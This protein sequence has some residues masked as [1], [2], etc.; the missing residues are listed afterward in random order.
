MSNLVY[1]NVDSRPIGVGV[2]LMGSGLWIFSGGPWSATF[3]PAVNVLACAADPLLPGV[4]VATIPGPALVPGAFVVQFY[5]LGSVWVAD[6][7][8]NTPENYLRAGSRRGSFSWD[9]G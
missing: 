1:S 5:K 3:D 4:Q 8:L 6:A 2:R 7:T 9:V